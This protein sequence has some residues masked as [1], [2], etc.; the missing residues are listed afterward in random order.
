M[1][2]KETYK[3][4]KPVPKARRR[5]FVWIVIDPN[6]PTKDRRMKRREAE[7]HFKLGQLAWINGSFCLKL[8]DERAK[9]IPDFL[10][11]ALP[12][13]VLESCNA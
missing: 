12:R 9:R 6:D 2:F 3:R 10:K 1:G 4:P 5:D 11:D 7:H 8:E 13:V